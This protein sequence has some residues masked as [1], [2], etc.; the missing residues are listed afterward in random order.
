MIKQVK[1]SLLPQESTDANAV[2][3][4]QER[5]RIAKRQMGLRTGQQELFSFVIRRSDGTRRK[6]AKGAIKKHHLVTGINR[7][8]G[9]ESS[10]LNEMMQE[11]SSL[12]ASRSH[13]ATEVTGEQKPSAFV[14]SDQ[15]RKEEYQSKRVLGSGILKKNSQRKA[16]GKDVRFQIKDLESA[17]VIEADDFFSGNFRPVQ[18]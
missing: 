7:K 2:L 10:M 5:D 8:Y 15:K 11:A 16:L 17:S 14:Q 12:N 1:P 18:K 6:L 9:D 13:I 3:L 4:E